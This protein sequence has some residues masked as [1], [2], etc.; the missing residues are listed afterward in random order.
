M[1]ESITNWDY[2]LKSLPGRLADQVKND[3]SRKL[4]TEYLDVVRRRVDSKATLSKEMEK[5]KQALILWESL[6]GP[7][8]VAQEKDWIAEEKAIRKELDIDNIKDVPKYMRAEKE[9]TR[10]LE[11]RKAKH[12][13]EK[14]TRHLKLNIAMMEKWAGE[15]SW[16][17]ELGMKAGSGSWVTHAQAWQ[18]FIC[19]IRG[20][21]EKDGRYQ[22][23]PPELDG[24]RVK[25]SETSGERTKKLRALRPY[26]LEPSDIDKLVQACKNVRD[27]AFIMVLYG[28]GFRQEEILNMK[29][30]DIEFTQLMGAPCVKVRVTGK[31]GT[32]SVVLTDAAPFVCDWKDKHPNPKTEAFVWA[33]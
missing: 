13:K 21:K 33:K 7:L 22:E 8:D 25:T 5:L 19:W 12:L 28:G 1:A 18:R 14:R 15:H 11:E 24:F 31:T 6:H 16:M 32:R 9:A 10:M 2:M 4:W 30:Q 23:Q 27:R 26:V 29:W 20:C 17:T 3:N